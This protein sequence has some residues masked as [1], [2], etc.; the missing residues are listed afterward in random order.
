MN[1]NLDNKKNQYH[2]ANGGKKYE[3]KKSKTLTKDITLED[4]L[5]EHTGCNFYMKRKLR[6]CN[7]EK[8][9]KSLFCG[10]HRP[11]D[12]LN[13]SNIANGNSE[14][15]R[16]PCPIDPSHSIYKHKLKS[17]LLICNVVQR[18]EVMSK[19]P[20]YCSN[21]NSG[22]L[23][24]ESSN[25][26]TLKSSNGVNIDL[27]VEKIKNCYK[28]NVK[29]YVEYFDEDDTEVLPSEVVVDPPV[30]NMKMFKDIEEVVVKNLS[31]SSTT[32]NKIR[33][34]QQDAS[35]LYQMVCILID[36]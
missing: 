9:P 23:I 15:E 29:Q 34:A 19:E 26:T 17:H 14:Q 33:H 35:I 27:L 28:N 25:N 3:K 16:I 12:E 6:F 5:K 22:S 20:F 30:K 24:N 21:C 18:E 13:A 4:L 36:R 2:Q 1:D 10:T 11:Q 32:F 7:L 31:G 8:C